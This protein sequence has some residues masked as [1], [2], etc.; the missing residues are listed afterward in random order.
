MRW[1]QPLR[2]ALQR[3]ALFAHRVTARPI[4]RATARRQHPVWRRWKRN[5]DCAFAQEIVALAS[6]AH[7]HRILF[8]VALG[9]WTGGALAQTGGA[10]PAGSQSSPGAAA[11][12]PARATT[13]T[14]TVPGAAPP[15]PS[16]PLNSQTALPSRLLPSPAASAT[17]PM[18]SGSLRDDASGRYGLARSPSGTRPQPAS[19]SLGWHHRLG[20]ADRKEPNHRALCR[21][22]EA[23]G[24]PNSHEQGGVVAHL[25][26]Y[27]ESTAEPSRRKHGRRR[28]RPRVP[29][30]RKIARQRLVAPWPLLRSPNVGGSRSPG[31]DVGRQSASSC[32]AQCVE[33]PARRAAEERSEERL[34]RRHSRAPR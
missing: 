30:H 15:A 7:M 6:E 17:S 2:Q 26:A 5:K 19:H 3:T 12:G 29:S 23:L 31:A 32:G 14:T 16:A 8:A 18:P 20:A 21:L 24:Q 1:P 25:S 11:P 34:A 27:R 13:P 10:P 4:G 33:G 28:L 22:R 9:I